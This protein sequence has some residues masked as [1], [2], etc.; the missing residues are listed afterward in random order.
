MLNLSDFHTVLHK[1]NV[2]KSCG[3]QFTLLHCKPCT[4]GLVKSCNFKNL[5]VYETKLNTVSRGLCN[6][7]P[8]FL[9]SLPFLMT[10]FLETC[11]HIQHDLSVFSRVYGRF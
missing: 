2:Y 8:H 3:E 6:L 9:R 4:F 7:L 10:F 1:V 5:K 11:V